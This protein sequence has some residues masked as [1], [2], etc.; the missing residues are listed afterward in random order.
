MSN[1][2]VHHNRKYGDRFAGC[3]LP[4]VSCYSN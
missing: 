1:I 3:T 2:K 4:G